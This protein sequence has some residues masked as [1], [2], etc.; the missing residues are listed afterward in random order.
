MRFG[1]LE[2]FFI[3]VAVLIIVIPIVIG[4]FYC[5]TLQ[6]ALNRCAPQNRAMSPGLV[7]LFLI[8]FFSLVWHFFIVINMAKSL[9]AEFM[10]R[11]IVEEPNPGQGIGL[12]TCILHCLFWVPFFGGLIWVGGLV[13]WIMYWT[14]IA[15]YSGKIAQPYQATAPP[16]GAGPVA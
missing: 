2:L 14:K 7:W 3:S 13:C 10:Y 15:G 9:H 11:G 5:L 12:A 1:A 6:K 16:T 4:I 8:P